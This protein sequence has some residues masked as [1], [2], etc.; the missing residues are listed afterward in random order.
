[1]PAPKNSAKRGPRPLLAVLFWIGVALAPAAAG[2]LLIADSSSLLRI[3]AVLA[4]S[5]VV[6]IGL[7]IAL[8]NDSRA[9]RD[10]LEEVIY[11]EIDG[12]HQDVRKDIE[13]AARATHRA[14]GEKLQALQD[15]V[16]VL[17]GRLDAGRV[18]PAVSPGSVTGAPGTTGAPGSAEHGARFDPAATGAVYGARIPY[19]RQPGEQVTDPGWTDGGRTDER[20]TTG[21]D[22]RRERDDARQPGYAGD[23]WHGG[24]EWAAQ[25]ATGGRWS[26]QS[27]DHT[28][29]YQ[30]RGAKSGD[31]SWQH[32][33]NWSRGWEEPDRRPDAP[34]PDYGYEFGERRAP[35]HDDYGSSGDRWR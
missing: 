4:L 10:E 23:S 8:R 34:E 25:S 33:G 3:A 12:L 7:S 11:E 5:S 28:A 14:F 13:T 27:G 9:V 6:L 2:L 24:G 17:R 35:S 19:Q 21:H 31:P 29:E 30:W 18:P 15:E 32:T 22:G 26:G 16:N 20:W 1:M